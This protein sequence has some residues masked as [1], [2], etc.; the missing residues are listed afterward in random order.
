VVASQAMQFTAIRHLFVLAALAGV[1]LGLGQP[2]I[3]CA[4]DMP[5]GPCCPAESD[6]GCG[7]DSGFPTG[8]G[9][10]D[11]TGCATQASDAGAIAST[12]DERRT[13]WCTTASGSDPPDDATRR[14]S[15]LT[16]PPLVVK[17][18]HLQEDFFAA[19]AARTYLLTARLRL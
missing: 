15:S 7:G 17:R 4:M 5:A 14:A 11:V 6:H 3:A 2:L 8:T 9:C 12:R 19:I 18:P 16:P 13:A 10:P 1:L